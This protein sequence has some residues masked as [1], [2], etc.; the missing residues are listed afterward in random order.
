MHFMQFNLVSYEDVRHVAHQCPA[1][2]DIRSKLFNGIKGCLSGVSNELL[3]EEYIAET[4]MNFDLFITYWEIVYNH[5]NN[6]P[7][8]EK[9]KTKYI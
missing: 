3:Y 7:W 4:N 1:T 2:Q 5:L 6:V 9:S 8:L